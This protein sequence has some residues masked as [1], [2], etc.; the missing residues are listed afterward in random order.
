MTKLEHRLEEYLVTSARIGDEKAL[1]QLVELRGP[2]LMAHAMRLLGDHEEARDTV[3]DT[4][5]EIIRGL[6]NLRDPRAFP[7]WATRIAT[8]RCA[9]LIKTKQRQR[10]VKSAV[11][12]EAEEAMEE[13]STASLEMLEMRR[14]IASLPP[15]HAAT[16]ALFYLDDMSIAEVAIALDIPVGTVKTRLMHARAKL[17]TIL[18]GDDHDEGTDEQARPDDRAGPDQGR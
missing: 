4:W 5:V 6:K 11:L 18:T 3:Q 14:A 15:D 13:D 1:A 8:R 2:R 7:A 12:A 9:S 10:D 16:I 17:K